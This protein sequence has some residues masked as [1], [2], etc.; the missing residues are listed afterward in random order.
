MNN[1]WLPARDSGMIDRIPVQ[2]DPRVI[3]KRFANTRAS[4]VNNH[5]RSIMQHHFDKS[6]VMSIVIAFRFEYQCPFARKRTY[7]SSLLL[8]PLSC[9]FD[10]TRL[11]SSIEITVT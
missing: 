4:S 11:D 8:L 1:P 7:S 3:V 10:L 9:T 6:L 2:S 5:D